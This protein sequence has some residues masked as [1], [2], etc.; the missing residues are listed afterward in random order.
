MF[1]HCYKKILRLKK[2]LNYYIEFFNFYYSSNNKICIN[3]IKLLFKRQ[4]NFKCIVNITIEHVFSRWN[5]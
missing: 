4:H 2:Q 5:D 1:I 3:I